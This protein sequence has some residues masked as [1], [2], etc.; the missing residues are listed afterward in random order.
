MFLTTMSFVRLSPSSTSSLPLP[1]PGSK[2]SLGGFP[3]VRANS[4]VQAG[5]GDGHVATLDVQPVER[6]TTLGHLTRQQSNLLLYFLK[7]LGNLDRKAKR[8]YALLAKKSYIVRTKF[9]IFIGPESDHWLCLSL[10][11]SLTD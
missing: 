11:H 2:S 10:T 7:V 4:D 3:K 6:D 1:L 8:V 9:S 5:V